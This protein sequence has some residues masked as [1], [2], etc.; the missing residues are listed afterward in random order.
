MLGI[1]DCIIVVF[2]TE[3]PKPVQLEAALRPPSPSH[4]ETLEAPRCNWCSAGSLEVQPLPSRSLTVRPWK[5]TFP[6]G[7]DRLPTIIFQ[8]L[9]VKLRG[10]MFYML[11]YLKHHFFKGRVYHY[12]IGTT[13]CLNGGWLPRIIYQC[14]FSTN[15]IPTKQKKHWEPKTCSM[16]GPKSVS[17]ETG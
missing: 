2:R 14:L 15:P 12:W 4:V 17:N 1:P 13:I 5:V 7:K 3:P 9:A 8:G 11:V 16:V 10:G 6:I